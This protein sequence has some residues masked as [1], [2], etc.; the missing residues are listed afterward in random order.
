MKYNKQILAGLVLSVIILPNTIFAASTTRP[1][2]EPREPKVAQNKFCENIE[3]RISNSGGKLG[4]RESQMNAKLDKRQAEMVSRRSDKDSKVGD[5]R[6]EALTK[7]TEKFKAALAKASTAEQKAALEDFQAG[8]KNA[9]A[10][11]QSAVDS[12]R[13]AF[14]QNADSIIS[15]RQ[16]KIEDALDARKSAV[17]TAIAKAKTDCANG[18]D[19]VTVRNN[20]Q[21]SVKLAQESFK[22]TISGL[23]DSKGDLKVLAETRKTAFE[24]AHNDFKNTLESL[25]KTLLEKL[26]K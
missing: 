20:L 26:Q 19:A 3:A 21:A 2:R 8:V 14:R 17:D 13:N 12:A 18:V 22:S 10:V 15:E 24:K 5:M 23:K 7:Q 6:A 16:D 9:V 25:K 1:I 4:E 11:R